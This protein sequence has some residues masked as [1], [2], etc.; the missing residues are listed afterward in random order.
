VLESVIPQTSL[1]FS[2]KAPLD[3]GC[4]PILNYV[5]SKNGVDLATTVS[6]SVSTFTDDI[7]T[8]GSIGT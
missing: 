8:G 1:V 3:N 5:V 2:W 7:S 6:A 4:L